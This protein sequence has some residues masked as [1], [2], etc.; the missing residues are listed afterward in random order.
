VKEGGDAQL[1]AE[2]A[3]VLDLEKNAQ[4]GAG[5]EVTEV[6]VERVAERDTAPYDFGLAGRFEPRGDRAHTVLVDTDVVE[7]DVG[8]L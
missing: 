3:E 8:V 6:E 1:S 7:G 4:V 5:V 2:V